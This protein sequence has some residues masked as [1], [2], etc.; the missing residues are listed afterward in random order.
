QVA[1]FARREHGP[2]LVHSFGPWPGVGLAAVRR[3]RR[4]GIDAVPVATSFSTYRHE[5]LGKGEGVAA[6]YPL[7]VRASI[8]GELLWPRLTVDPNENRGLTGARTVFVNYRSVRDIIEAQCGADVRFAS[9]TY[10]AETAFLREGMPRA[11][12][13]APIDKLTPDDAPLLV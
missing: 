7:A 12:R 11:A 5:T 9:M 10:S 3:L 6:G 4:R 13:P 1:R 8:W 2:Y